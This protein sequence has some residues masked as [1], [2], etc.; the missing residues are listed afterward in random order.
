MSAARVSLVHGYVL[1]Q[2]PWRDTSMLIE[3]FTPDAGR[4][5]LVARGAR[6]ARSRTRP[7]LEPFQ[8]LLLSW[9]GRGDLHT[10]TGVESSGWRAPPVGRALLAGFYCSE[11][12]LRLTVREDPNAAAF[13]AYDRAVAALAASDGGTGTES[14]LR[15]FELDLLEALGYAPPLTVD[16]ATG[17]PVRP[18]REY[19][20]LPEH[21]PVAASGP[22]GEG[23]LRVPGADLLAVGAGR[24]DDPRALQSA[25]RILRSALQPLLG[26]RPLKSREMY[27]A[28]YGSDSRR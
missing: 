21:G 23:T 17:E 13:E 26:P 1:H 9:S 22:A 8:P 11:L 2:R 25:R 4:V 5:G 3:A 10:L 7:L 6:R 19:D 20:Y 18:D 15:H 12:V 28:M 14:P 24:L 27:R 16:M